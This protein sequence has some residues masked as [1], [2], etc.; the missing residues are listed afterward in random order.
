M[1]II[2]NK[3]DLILKIE[4]DPLLLMEVA[5]L[6]EV[7]I[8]FLKNE[9]KIGWKSRYTPDK[10]FVYINFVQLVYLL[11]QYSLQPPP[12]IRLLITYN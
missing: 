1:L 11:L 6:F 9:Y 2:I 4:I 3:F 7:K 12:P 10:I 5:V 8:N